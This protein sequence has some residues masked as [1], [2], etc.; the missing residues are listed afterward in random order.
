MLDRKNR[1][2]LI[3]SLVIV[4]ILT[5]SLNINTFL[6][7][8][9]QLTPVGEKLLSTKQVK[10][11]A[12]YIFRDKYKINSVKTLDVGFSVNTYLGKDKEVLERAFHYT[13]DKYFQVTIE[14]KKQK[15]KDINRKSNAINQ[16]V[17]FLIYLINREYDPSIKAVF[18][19]YYP[20]TFSI[21]D[22]GETRIAIV[23]DEFK[24]EY[25]RLINAGF[26]GR[27]LENKL[28]EKFIY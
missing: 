17:T 13:S 24:Q 5:L 23:I 27:D 12:E 20:K 4:A 2:L 19:Y 9:H 28:E 25:Q 7:Y 6:I 10:K 16:A 1:K 11:D 15:W 22:N 18:I 3:W 26:K 21:D 14:D 8:T